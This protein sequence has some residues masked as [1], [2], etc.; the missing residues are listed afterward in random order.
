VR[1]DEES[2]FAIPQGA[3]FSI[4]VRHHAH[5]W[6]SIALPDGTD[7][8]ACGAGGSARIASPG[9]AL[10]KLRRLLATP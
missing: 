8:T 7:V 5:A 3:D 2:L 4:H 10:P 9:A 1:L 6:C